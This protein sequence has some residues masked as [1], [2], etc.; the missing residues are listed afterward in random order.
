MRVRVR[1]RVRFRVR[2]RSRVRVRVRVR[3]SV[4][5]RGEA[6][7]V[8]GVPQRGGGV[9]RHDEGEVE[10]AGRGEHAQAHVERRAPHLTG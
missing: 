9:A 7:D 2:T 8:V 4:R 1:V 5:V 6:Q 3:V 10:R